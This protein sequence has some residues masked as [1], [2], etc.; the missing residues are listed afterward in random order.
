MLVD[1][2]LF[3]FMATR[4]KYVN[5][6]K[7]QVTSSCNNESSIKSSHD[8]R[9]GGSSENGRKAG[10]VLTDDSEETGL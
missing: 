10:S 6:G 5:L 7:D 4:Y 3:G 9:T 2:I 1:A 8:E